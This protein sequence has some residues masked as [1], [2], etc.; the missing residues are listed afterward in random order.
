[1]G[2]QGVRLDLARGSVEE[3]KLISRRGRTGAVWGRYM[4][5]PRR[6]FGRGFGVVV[7]V[8]VVVLRC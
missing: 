5:N 1:M 6:R 8:V 7:V 3:L 4:A 2:C